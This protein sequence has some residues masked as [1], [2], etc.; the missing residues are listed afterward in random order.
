MMADTSALL[1]SIEAATQGLLFP[2]ESDFPIEVYRFGVEEPRPEFL[3]RSQGL[4]A[5]TAVEEMSVG[6]FFEG[7]TE[8]SE[9]AGEA[10]R[11]TAERF[12]ALVALLERELTHLR[13]YRV[14]KVDIGVFVLGRHPSGEWLGVTTK[15][16]ET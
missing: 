14:G 15:L 10:D 2:S 8:A 3:L 6:D 13:V 11:R 4:P 12:A 9:D 16:V 1:R 7:L 5:E